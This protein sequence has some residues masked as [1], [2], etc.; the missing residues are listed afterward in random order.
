MRT[1]V[2]VA[3]VISIGVAMFFI[4]SLMAAA[5]QMGVWEEPESLDGVPHLDDRRA[6]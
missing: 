4:W 1:I 2:I 3:A 6:S 5:G